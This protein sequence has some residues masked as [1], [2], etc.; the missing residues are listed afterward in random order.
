MENINEKEE[1]RRKKAREYDQ[2]IFG[3]YFEQ[4]VAISKKMVEGFCVEGK[5]VIGIA[6]PENKEPELVFADR[7]RFIPFSEI[8]F[9][10]L[11]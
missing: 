9:S 7:S 11:I 8:N 10:G 4:V 3:K 2:K 1:K 6:K 5:A